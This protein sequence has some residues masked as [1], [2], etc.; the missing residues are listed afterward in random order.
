MTTELTRE[1]FG[2]I[3]DKYL[4][5]NNIKQK[6]W[7]AKLGLSR[8]TLFKYRHGARRIPIPVLIACE[9][10]SNGE[11]NFNIEEIK[12]QTYLT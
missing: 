1:E 5:D 3:L 4:K 7:A 10:I 2:E 11:L 12:W 6:D 8:D 9:Y